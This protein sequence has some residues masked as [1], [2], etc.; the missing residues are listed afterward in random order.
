[1]RRSSVLPVALV[2][3]ALI[4][5]SKS[6]PVMAQVG[7]AATNTNQAVRNLAAVRLVSASSDAA[8]ELGRQ[9][10]EERCIRCHGPN[11]TGTKEVPAPIFGD[12]PTSDLA[13]VISRTMPEDAVGDCVGDDARAVAEWM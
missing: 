1:M 8:M 5:V 13:D 6:P 7:A 11:G 9:I 3:A 4:C 10:Y 2:C 12:R